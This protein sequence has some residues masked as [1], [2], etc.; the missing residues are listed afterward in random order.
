MRDA[1]LLGMGN[2]GQVYSVVYD[3]EKC[4]LK[5][6][7][8][9][10][11]SASFKA[12]MECMQFVG[13]AGGAPIPL[14][15]CP[16]MPALIMTL[17]GATTLDTH[18]VKAERT[19]GLSLQH[20]LTLA[21]SLA[22]R[23]QE[24]HE[25]SFVHCDLKSTNVTLDLDA[26]Q[27]P[28][29]VYIVDFGLSNCI[30]ESLMPQPKNKALHWYCDCLFN[31]SPLTEKCDL[32]GL[33]I[34]FQDMFRGRKDIPSDL[35]K[36]AALCTRSSHDERPDLES[37]VE[38]ITKACQPREETE[39]PRNSDNNDSSQGLEG[40]YTELPCLEAN[41]DTQAPSRKRPHDHDDHQDPQKR[42][43][44]DKEQVARSPAQSRYF[45]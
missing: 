6:G 33:G 20:T 4:A 30:G 43:R 19:G 21:L 25:A 34:I 11:D 27:N 24:V 3:D 10:K 39:P 45:W 29:S 16:E 18:L 1:R 44:E 38:C 9:R 42:S 28:E 22:E 8:Y 5:V 32:L 37:V 2:F 41:V 14:A 31:G 40:I 23:L 35:V 36:L 12:E 15:F 13:G 7:Y 26:E 17:C